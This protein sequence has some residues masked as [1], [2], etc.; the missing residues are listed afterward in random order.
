MGSKGKEF[1]VQIEASVIEYRDQPSLPSMPSPFT[2]CTNAAL[3]QINA[4]HLLRR[5]AQRPCVLSFSP[6]RTLYSA[7]LAR[8]VPRGGS[9]RAS[10]R[11]VLP[12]STALP[13][14]PPAATSASPPLLRKQAHL[15]AVKPA[16]DMGSKAWR[17]TSISV[18]HRA[19]LSPCTPRPRPYRRVAAISSSSSPCLCLSPPHFLPP[20]PFSPHLSPF[21]PLPAP[22]SSPLLP[23][24]PR[25]GV[26]GGVR[27]DAGLLPAAPLRCP[28]A[29]RAAR[30]APGGVHGAHG[31]EGARR[32]AGGRGR[33]AHLDR[34]LPVLRLLPPAALG[35]HG[36]R[37]MPAQPLPGLSISL[38][39][40][41]PSPYLPCAVRGDDA[42]NLPLT[43]VAQTHI[44]QHQFPPSCDQPRL[45]LADWPH[46]NA[47][48]AASGAGEA[49]GGGGMGA[50][51]GVAGEVHVVGGLLGL[52]VLFN[53]TLVVTPGSFP[54][55]NH[56]ACSAPSTPSPSLPPTVLTPLPTTAAP[57]SLAC[58]FA[59]L[60][61]PLC[62]QA[63]ADAMAAHPPVPALAC[64][65]AQEAAQSASQGL[66]ELEALLTSADPVVRVCTGA[67]S[68]HQLLLLANESRVA[69]PLLRCTRPSFHVPT[70]LL[71]HPQCSLP[72]A[73]PLPPSSLCC[74]GA[75][76]WGTAVSEASQWVEVAGVVPPHD[77]QREQL[78]WWRSQAVRF[79]FRWPSAHLCHVTNL[80]RHISY[81]RYIAAQMHSAAQQQAAIIRSL[82]AGPSEA[83]KSIGVDT[84]AEAKFLA[85]VDIRSGPSL[86]GRLW[87][88]L[89][90]EGCVKVKEGTWGGSVI[91][92]EVYEGVGREAYIMRPI[93]SVH[94]SVGNSEAT[95]GAAGEA[96]AA[97][98]SADPNTTLPAASPQRP[99]E[100][101]NELSEHRDW[102]FHSAG[103]SMGAH[104]G[105]SPPSGLEGSLG[106]AMGVTASMLS[107]LLIASECDYFVGALSSSSAKLLNE[108]RSTNGRLQSGFIT[109]DQ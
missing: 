70:R 72:L 13:S 9:L 93:V 8:R 77:V 19:S 51:E 57:Q 84:V 107:Q 44:W 82:S 54:H 94:V 42:S 38:P 71:S 10:T 56:S 1:L 100:V 37:S 5:P 92:D 102:T 31:G 20:L 35:R 18:R 74:R 66:D 88:A 14:L 34:A 45:L 40:H 16:R 73:L 69:I 85:S 11:W 2:F 33:D 59:P 55:A 26:A 101:S 95:A 6:L 106:G 39:R 28:A 58:F 43:R 3:T 36:I 78:H 67:L 46:L 98:G 53:R 96:V 79:L 97:A 12:P 24:S 76:H 30:A 83:D 61:G 87:P 32:G 89:G 68:R 4:T 15:V 80:I 90:F 103:G 81:G 23:S 41:S 22:P 49:E 21:F 65:A 64:T 52:A 17:G 91:I 62:D 105:Q 109:L 7:T 50:M 25:A 75:R 29:R 99:D 27:V 63:A 86:E 47:D 104:D 48:E 108:L 60:T